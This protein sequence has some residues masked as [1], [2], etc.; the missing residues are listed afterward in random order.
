MDIIYDSAEAACSCLWFP[1]PSP[2]TFVQSNLFCEFSELWSENVWKKTRYFFRWTS[3]SL[4]GR[5]R[6]VEAKRRKSVCAGVRLVSC[7]A[8]HQALQ[9]TLSKCL[10]STRWYSSNF[11][12]NFEVAVVHVEMWTHLFHWHRLLPQWTVLRNSW[13]TQLDI[14]KH[15]IGKK[16]CTV[17]YF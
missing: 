6:K 14:S 9:R 12:G 11:G 1:C 16:T 8:P 5:E 15:C 10:L 13:L 17:H 7:I 4:A 3:W 2:I